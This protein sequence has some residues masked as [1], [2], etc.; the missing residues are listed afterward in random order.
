MDQPTEPPQPAEID[1][2]DPSDAVFATELMDLMF[3]T[4]GCAT[5]KIRPARQP[6]AKPRSP[7]SAR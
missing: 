1:E 6:A 3:D 5:G 4:S 2:P 7:R